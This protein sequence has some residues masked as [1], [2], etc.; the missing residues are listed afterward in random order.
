MRDTWHGSVR[1]V[2]TRA[3]DE[4]AA[5]GAAN[6]EAEHLLLAVA[7]DPT[8]PGARALADVGWNHDAIL[9]ALD[10]ER[11][12]AL[13]AAGIEPV[14]PELL[15]ATRRQA[16]PGWG[17]SAREAVRRAGLGVGRGG[18]QRTDSGDAAVVLGAVE[19]ETGTVPRM[20]AYGRIDREALTTRLLRK[21]TAR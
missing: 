19:A 20:L 8:L 21:A 10:T 1:G 18:G 3:I 13:R 11:A 12:A 17:A 2:V 7:A 5:R 15:T 9:A 6:V 16:R 4:A 14:A